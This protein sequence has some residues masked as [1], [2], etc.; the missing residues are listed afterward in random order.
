MNKG[1]LFLLALWASVTTIGLAQNQT[2]AGYNAFG[3][4]HFY[5]EKTDGNWAHFH[6]PETY[7]RVTDTTVLFYSAVEGFKPLENVPD[8]PLTD[9]FFAEK[10]K[11]VFFYES[12][13]QQLAASFAAGGKATSLG[14]MVFTG[15]QINIPLDIV[16]KSTYFY[17]INY[18]GDIQKRALI[19]PKT[20]QNKL[21][22]KFRLEVR[23][24]TPPK[25]K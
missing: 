22:G 5:W 11:D 1:F 23:N 8:L 12:K 14:T 19:W 17:E 25:K 2:K 4:I 3:E 13:G 20:V 18:Q 24:I 10:G 7:F 21:T 15:L 6:N 16:K 9:M